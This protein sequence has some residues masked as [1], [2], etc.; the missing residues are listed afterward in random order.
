MNSKYV[1]MALYMISSKGVPLLLIL[2]CVG[3]SYLYINGSI[4]RAG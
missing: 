1:R 4:L 3:R 2:V